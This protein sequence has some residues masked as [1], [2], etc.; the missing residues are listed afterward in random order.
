MHPVL[1]QLLEQ[2]TLE[3]GAIVAE[4]I[5]SNLAPMVAEMV[6]NNPELVI[7][8]GVLLGIAYYMYKNDQQK[9]FQIN[10]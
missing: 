5:V 6:A 2:L 3:L 1:L 7:L 10:H 4:K 9:N 8:A